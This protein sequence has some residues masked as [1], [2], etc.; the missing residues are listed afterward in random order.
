M[1]RS[2]LCNLIAVL[3]K[4]AKIKFELCSYN[5]PY[6][7]EGTVKEFIN[8]N[9][10]KAFSTDYICELTIYGDSLLNCVANIKLAPPID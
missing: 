9:Y 3:D 5:Q 7:F 10:Y 6:V 2:K 1:V 8:S 4:Y